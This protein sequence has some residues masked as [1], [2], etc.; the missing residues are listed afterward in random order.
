MAPTLLDLVV[1]AEEVEDGEE[2][3]PADEGDEQTVLHHEGISGRNE[4]AREH[5]LLLVGKSLEGVQRWKDHSP[6]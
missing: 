1:E 4:P 3:D 5:G 2:E 6:A